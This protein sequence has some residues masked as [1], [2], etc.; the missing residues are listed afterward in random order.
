MGGARLLLAA[1]I[2]QVVKGVRR[3]AVALG[4]AGPHQIEPAPAGDPLHQL[5]GVAVGALL[6][7]LHPVAPQG[8]DVSHPCLLQPVQ[9]PQQSLL[10][11]VD[12]GQVGQGFHPPGADGA[13]QLHRQV[14][15]DAGAPRA[16]GHADKVRL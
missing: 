3:L 12:A 7:P 1:Q 6:G 8:E 5:V 2:L 14:V 10:V 15:L 13:G 11:G 9:K 16:E 4:V